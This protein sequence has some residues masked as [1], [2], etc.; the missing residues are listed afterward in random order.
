[1]TKL[2]FVAFLI[3]AGWMLL[4]PKPKRGAASTPRDEAEALA[5]LGLDASADGDAVRAAHRRLVSAVHP[6]RGGSLE[7][8][9]RVN[10]ARDM[11]LRRAR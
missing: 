7:L 11:L 9:R 5:V 1:M 3:W 2:L 4:R 6:D 10:A 8:T